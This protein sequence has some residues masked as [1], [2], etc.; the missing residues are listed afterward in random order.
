MGRKAVFLDRDGVLNQAIVKDGKPFPPRT[1]GELC[2]LDEAF[3]GCQRLAAAGFTLICVTNQPDVARG[4]IS[5]ENL[6]A[7][8]AAVTNQ[9]GLDEMRACP[10]SDE[11]HCHC[12]KPKPGML[13]DAAR[14]HGLDLS[15]CY[16]VGDRWRDIDA[17]LAAGCRTIFIDY[18][19]AERR[20]EGMNF[21]CKSLAEAAQFI[22]DADLDTSVN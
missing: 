19:Y 3:E 21:I 22:L 2:I 18:G 17:G 7:I 5:A 16:M 20:P 13:L 9:L 14:H 4:I 12:R 6:A 8:N 11:D 1:P 15:R 10:H